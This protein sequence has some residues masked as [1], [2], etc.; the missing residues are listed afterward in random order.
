MLQLYDEFGS[1][2]KGGVLKQK[3]DGWA[4]YVLPDGRRRLVLDQDGDGRPEGFS[5]TL[6]DETIITVVDSNQDGKPEILSQ[7]DGNG[8]YFDDTNRNGTFDRLRTA[9]A[10]G[11]M[12]RVRIW[13]DADE[14]GHFEETESWLQTPAIPV[15]KPPRE[16][17]PSPG[18]ETRGP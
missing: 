12:F 8:W 6:T 3:A 1:P 5:D 17:V 10:E 13:V 4:E 15:L 11:D 9:F 2:T 18:Q 16:P 7:E 14:D